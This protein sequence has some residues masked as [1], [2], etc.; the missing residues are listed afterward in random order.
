VSGAARRLAGRLRRLPERLL[1]PWR[2]GRARARLRTLGAPT[3]VLVVCHGNICRSPYAA[4]ALGRLIPPPLGD[5]LRI[6]SAGFVGPN[7]RA[8]PEAVAV[9]ARRGV[10]LKGHRSQV[11]TPQLVASAGLIVVMESWQGRAIS[12]FY[13]PAGR[14]I[15][16]LGDLD[17]GPI[18]TRAIK[19][20]VEQPESVFAESYDRIDRCLRELV[21]ISWTGSERR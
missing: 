19:D 15:L 13:G 20:P 18:E 1:H 2:R 10:D 12:S 5:G 3:A 7:R 14:D 17:P 11:L 21:D 8:P 16:V 4:A 6:E 9:A